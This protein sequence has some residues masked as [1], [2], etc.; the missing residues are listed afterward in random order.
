MLW[1]TFCLRSHCEPY[2]IEEGSLVCQRK[3]HKP[4]YVGYKHSIRKK[5]AETA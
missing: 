3:K 1:E 2:N 4:P 5:A